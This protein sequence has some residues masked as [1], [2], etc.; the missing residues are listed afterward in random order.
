MLTDL[1]ARIPRA[2][3]AIFC[4]HEGESVEWA[5]PGAPPSGMA[6][7][8]EYELKLC[9]AQLAAAWLLF[10][11]RSQEHGGGAIREL[12]LGTS[13]GTL[14]AQ[15]VAEG[16]YAVLLIAPGRGASRAIYELRE[17]AAHLASEM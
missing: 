10:E 4:D 12:Q 3:G 6:Q 13:L 1:L 16:Y 14:L 5:L 11:E 15:A 7:L 17:T 8:S 9:G 2:R